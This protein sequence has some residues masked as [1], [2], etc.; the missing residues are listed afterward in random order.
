MKSKET[1]LREVEKHVKRAG[2][3]KSTVST[4]FIALGVYA[5]MQ[6]LTSAI[7]QEVVAGSAL[8]IVGYIGYYVGDKLKIDFKE[9]EYEMILEMVKEWHELEHQSRKRL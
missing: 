6:G 7:W 3:T 4:T 9:Q 1:M 5:V 2:F 8:A